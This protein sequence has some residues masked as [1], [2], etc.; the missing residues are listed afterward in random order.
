[1]EFTFELPKKDEKLFK[2]GGN[3]YEFAHFGWG[4]TETEFYG[5][6]KGY[7]ESADLLVNSSVA[8]RDISMLDTSVFPILFLYR[9]YLELAMKS[10]FLRFSEDN[11]G[12][13]EDT[14]KK[15]SH[16]LMSIWNKVK[17]ILEPLGSEDK[18]MLVT[19]EEYIK[20]FHQFDKSSFT[21]RYPITK[22]LDRVLTSEKRINLINL[23]DRIEELYNFF[24]GA[25]I[26]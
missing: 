24:S 18:E 17:P 19:V 12:D 2:D 10:I 1:M 13:K 8:S 5:Y 6:M 3:Y 25:V 4:S 9:Q 16:N 7:K 20:E 11:L 15:S 14:I 23:R 21:F 22:E 26:C